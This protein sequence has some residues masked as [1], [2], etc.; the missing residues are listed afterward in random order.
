MGCEYAFRKED[1]QDILKP[2]ELAFL[3]QVAR[4][5]ARLGARPVHRKLSDR[6]VH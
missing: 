5:Y 6:I 3:A 4:H 1:T 2:L